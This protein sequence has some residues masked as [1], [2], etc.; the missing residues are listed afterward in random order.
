MFVLLFN[1]FQNKRKKVF[2]FKEKSFIKF[3]TT[4]G[5]LLSQK[6]DTYLVSKTIHI[7]SKYYPPSPLSSSNKWGKVSGKR[8]QVNELE[9]KFEVVDKSSHSDSSLDIIVI[10]LKHFLSPTFS[11]NVSQHQNSVKYFQNDLKLLTF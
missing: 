1:R 8:Y 11:L 9:T 6:N 5:V 4:W 10:G 3:F 7:C 2:F